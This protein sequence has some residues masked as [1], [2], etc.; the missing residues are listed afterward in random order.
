[1]ISTRLASAIDPQAITTLR[2]WLDEREIQ[3]CSIHLIMGPS[4]AA[5]VAD[6]LRVRGLEL[7]LLPLGVDTLTVAGVADRGPSTL[8]GEQ[9]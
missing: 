4:I 3:D 2:E 1:M 5:S 6:S 7:Q 9:Q 8:Q